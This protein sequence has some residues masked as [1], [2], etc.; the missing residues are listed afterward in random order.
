MSKSN[1][2]PAVGQA[3]SGVIAQRSDHP[4]LCTLVSQLTAVL[5]LPVAEMVNERGLG[6]HHTT[7]YRCVQ[8]YGPELEKGCRP[9]LRPSNDSWR[10]NQTYIEVKGKWKYLYRAVDSAGSARLLFTNS[11]R[12]MQQR[13]NGS[14]ARL[15]RACHNQ[16]PNG[17]SPVAVDCGRPAPCARWTH[18][19]LLLSIRM[20]LTRNL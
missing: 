12:G 6:V 17:Q 5:P 3:T 18:R 19:E 4:A 11:A 2:Y 10:V 9:H 20:P 8:E 13:Q 1:P 16:A 7:I 14:S 15:R